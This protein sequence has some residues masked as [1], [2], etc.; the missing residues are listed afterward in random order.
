[1]TAS[2]GTADLTRPDQDSTNGHSLVSDKPPL[3]PVDERVEKALALRAEGKSW[4]A[5]ALELKCDHRGLMRAVGRRCPDALTPQQTPESR[6]AY[7]TERNAELLDESGRQ[8]GEALSKGELTGKVLSTTYGIL[9]DK[10]QRLEGWGSGSAEGGSFGDRLAAAMMASGRM[11]KVTIT[12]E[13]DDEAI[14][15]TP[16]RVDEG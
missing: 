4:R 5:C 11:P 16:V 3:T 15:V 2:K 12:V 14:D 10:Q 6:R 1:M 13:P 7:F 9:A 8:L